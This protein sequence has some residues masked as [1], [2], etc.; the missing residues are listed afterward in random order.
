MSPL[1]YIAYCTLKSFTK[2][3][4]LQQIHKAVEEKYTK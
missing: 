1:L 4:T 2:P 3:I